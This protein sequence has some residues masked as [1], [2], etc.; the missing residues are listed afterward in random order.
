MIM[1]S[2]TLRIY[3]DKRAHTVRYSHN[4]QNFDILYHVTPQVA[5]NK[6]ACDLRLLYIFMSIRSA[7]Y[8]LALPIVPV[9]IL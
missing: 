6:R 1:I 7:K 9:W 2:P 4:T 5:L 8:P 3:A